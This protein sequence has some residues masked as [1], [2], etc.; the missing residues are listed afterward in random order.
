L[1]GW[2]VNSASK[3]QVKAVEGSITVQS[4]IE[5][6]RAEVA[7]LKVQREILREAAILFASEE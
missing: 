7:E 4:E 5:M 2:L 1:H 3:Q 6:L